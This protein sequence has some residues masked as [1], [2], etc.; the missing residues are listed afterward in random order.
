MSTGYSPSAAHTIAIR[1]MSGHQSADRQQIH[2]F[3]RGAGDEGGA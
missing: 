3:E 2:D 1:G